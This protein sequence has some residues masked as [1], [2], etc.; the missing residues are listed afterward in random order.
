M[1]ST[2]ILSSF[3]FPILISAQLYFLS[4]FLSLVEHLPLPLLTNTT[5][6]PWYPAAHI[7]TPLTGPRLLQ[8][9]PHCP[10]TTVWCRTGLN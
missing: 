4:H 3:L 1:R 10:S 2:I 5:A 8:F 6:T 7:L 9:Y